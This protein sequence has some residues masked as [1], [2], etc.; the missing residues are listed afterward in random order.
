MCD[1][2]IQEKHA[3]EKKALDSSYD[4]T[5][6]LAIIRNVNYLVTNLELEVIL[7]CRV[8]F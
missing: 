5:K 3:L 6:E 1:E 7:F 8:A 2:Y 4:Y